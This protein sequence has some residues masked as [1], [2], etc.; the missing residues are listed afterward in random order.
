MVVARGTGELRV[1]WRVNTAACGPPASDRAFRS[2]YENID[3]V[4]RAPQCDIISYYQE[5]VY[6]HLVTEIREFERYENTYRTA[7]SFESLANRTKGKKQTIDESDHRRIELFRG[8]CTN[9]W[10]RKLTCR[11]ETGY[12]LSLLYTVP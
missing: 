7:T 1:N 8:N 12:A 2:R 4:S 11:N 10:I 3:S 9:E 5:Q 6:E